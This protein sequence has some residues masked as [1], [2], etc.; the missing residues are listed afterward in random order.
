LYLGK[1]VWVK[2]VSSGKRG[3]GKPQRWAICAIFFFNKNTAFFA[4]FGKIA[5]LKQ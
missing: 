4:Y 3:L 1:R 2:A 5:I